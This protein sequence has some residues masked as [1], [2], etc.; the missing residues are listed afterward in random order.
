M[1]EFAYIILAILP[2]LCAGL[3]LVT[4]GIAF[5]SV[6]WPRVRGTIDISIYDREWEANSSGGRTTY[7]EKGKFY[8]LYSYTIGGMR[9]QGTRISLV[10][11]IEWQVSGSPDLGSARGNSRWYREGS[12]VDVYYCPFYP[13]W[14]CLEP[15]GFIF[16]ALLSLGTVI[17]F[18][19]R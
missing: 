11:D 9:F 2:Y 1:P 18:C 16:A 19:V 12:L 3:S 6:N 17:W 13:K 10:V 5:W 4:M 7:E 14:A 8:L 15:G